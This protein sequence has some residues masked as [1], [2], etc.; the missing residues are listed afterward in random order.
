M[1]R[2]RIPDHQT[3]TQR[4]ERTA[5]I[6]DDPPRDQSTDRNRHAQSRLHGPSELVQV[7]IKYNPRQCEISSATQPSSLRAQSP[8]CSGGYNIALG[9][10]SLKLKYNFSSTGH[11]V[12][13]I[14][15]P[16]EH[17]L[18]V[19]ND[20]IVIETQPARLE[21]LR[22]F[23][24]CFAELLA[25]APQASCPNHATHPTKLGTTVKETSKYRST[26]K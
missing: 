4:K 16:C 9:Y 2:H 14:T 6:Q 20:H 21:R 5:A 11:D 3:T 13:S 26:G 12:S 23:C 8:P 22:W 1:L 25:Q 19:E 17:K 15:A 24:S 7:E 18:N 10:N